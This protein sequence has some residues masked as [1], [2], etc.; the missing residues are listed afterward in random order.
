MVALARN[1]DLIGS[2]FLTGLT[3]VFVTRLRQAPA[4]QM[5]A[6]V[7]LIC[8]HHSYCSP[9][10][11]P[12]SLLLLLWRAQFPPLPTL[13]LLSDGPPLS[14]SDLPSFH[15]PSKQCSRGDAY[16]KRRRNRQ[17]RVSLDALS[18]VIQEFFGSIAA[19]FRGTPHY[20]HAILYQ[21]GDRAGCTRS[22]VS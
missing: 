11:T 15:H 19:L 9:F 13:D 18:R 5:R 8:R 3:A 20:S 17:H 2:R 1:L 21:I 16:R 4:W 12:S 22:P 6:L 10:L 14:V 7:L